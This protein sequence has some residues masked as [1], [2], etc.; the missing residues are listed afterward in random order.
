MM[1]GLRKRAL[2]PLELDLQVARLNIVEE[3]LARLYLAITDGASFDEQ[4]GVLELLTAK[5]AIDTGNYWEAIK[6]AEQMH[7]RIIKALNEYAESQRR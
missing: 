3:N 7:E 5:L 4:R 1:F 6:L 2:P